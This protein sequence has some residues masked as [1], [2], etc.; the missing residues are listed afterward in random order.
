MFEPNSVAVSLPVQEEL[1]P[2]DLIALA[3]EA[4]RHG[5]AG[6]FLG[7]IAGVEAFSTLAAIALATERVQLASGVVS[8]YTRSAALTAMGFATLAGLAGDRVIAGL[9]TGSHTVVEDWHGRE[10]RAPRRTMERF[11]ADF[12]RAL[13]GGRLERGFRLQQPTADV[14]VLLGSF[15]PAMLRLAG[16]IGD[17]V[18]LAFCP[19]EH[20][21]ERIAFV[22]E[23]A[24]AA[25]RDPDAL[26]IA[27]YVNAYAGPHVDEALERFRRLVLQYAVL[28][29]HRA[30]FVEAF[31]EIDRATELW[32]AGDRRAALALVG[33][34]TVRALCPV[35]SADDVVR[36]LERVRAAGVTLPVLFPQSLRP[37]DAETPATT[38]ALVASERALR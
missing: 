8:I 35:G 16:A 17:G 5:Y 30:G 31:A 20:L 11:V 38:L 4:E 10:L 14:P 7:E 33:D 6:V 15:N 3:V 32:Q 2:G 18:L 26:T 25:G 1:A 22:R 29:T 19:P 21:A 28:P 34:D 36:H 9:G 24:S 37:G 13:A 27:A 12:R 23:G